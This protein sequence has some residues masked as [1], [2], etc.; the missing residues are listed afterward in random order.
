MSFTD[1]HAGMK[2]Q[3]EVICVLRRYL[4]GVV[5]LDDFAH[6]VI[7]LPPRRQEPN[8]LKIAHPPHQQILAHLQTRLPPLLEHNVVGATHCAPHLLEVCRIV[9]NKISSA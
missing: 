3:Q 5:H 1:C 2:A 6:L 4:A 7:V 9:A 8:Y